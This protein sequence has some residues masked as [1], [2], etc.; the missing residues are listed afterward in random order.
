MYYLKYVLTR[1]SQQ[2][3]QVAKQWRKLSVH[4]NNNSMHVPF[5]RKVLLKLRNLN[6][7][8]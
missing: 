5:L 6:I 2:L 3:Q 4:G 7:Y 1:T 8:I